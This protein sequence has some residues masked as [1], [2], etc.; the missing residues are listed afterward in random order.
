MSAQLQSLKDALVNNV[1]LEE[2]VEVNQRHLI[3]KILARYSAEFTV[4]RELLQNSN[5]AGATEVQIHFQTNA[6]TR[7]PSLLGKGPQVTTVIYKNNGRPFSDEDFGR[8]RKIAE[9]NPDEQKI[10]FFGVGF[11]SLFSICEEPFVTSGNQSMAFLWKGDMLYTKK[12]PI[13]ESEVSQWTCFFLGLREPIDIPS[14]QEFGKFLATSL[15][16]TANLKKVEVFVDEDRTLF[17]DKKIADP[18]PL[19]FA[20]GVYTLTSPNRMF[21]LESVVIRH[22]Q[23]DVEVLPKFDK[24]KLRRGD[25]ASHTIFMRTAGGRLRVQLDANL[26]KEMERTTKKRPPQTTEMQIMFS[27]FDEYESSTKSG[28]GE[29][30]FEDLV[31]SLGKQGRVFIGNQEILSVSGLLSRILYEDDMASIARLYQEMSLDA[32]SVTWLQNRAAHTMASFTYKPSTPSPLVGRILGMYFFQ[33]GKNPLSILS[34]KGV[35][36]ATSVRIMNEKMKGF[37]KEV[38]VIPEVIASKCTDMVEALKHK[39]LR[40]LGLDDVFRELESRS[41]NVEEMVAVMRWWID[42][43]KTQAVSQTELDRFLRSAVVSVGDK[44]VVLN[45]IRS[46]ANSKLVPPDLPL[47]ETVLP[48]EV[49]KNFKKE[50]LEGFFGSWTELSLYEWAVH[51]TNLADF[52]SDTTLVGKILGNISRHYGNITNE[53]RTHLISLLQ[54]KPCIPTKLGLKPPKDAYFKTVTLFPDLPIVDLKSPKSVSDTFLRALGVREHVELQ[55]VFDR[56][57]TLNWD[58]VQLVKYLS[59]V[60]GKLQ[61]VEI[62]RL[63]IS[64]L[65]L[66]EGAEEGGKRYRA[67]E[68]FAP[69]DVLRGFGVPIFS[70]KGKWKQGTDEARFMTMLGMQTYLPVETLVTLASTSPPATRPK[71]LAYFVDHH[72]TFYSHTYNPTTI[73]IPFLPTTKGVLAK[74]SEVFADPQSGVMG[75][76]VLHEELRP[77]AEKFGVGQHPGVG[78]LMDWLRKN[79]VQIERAGEVFGYLATRQG[80]FTRDNWRELSILRFIPVQ[81]HHPPG[82][83]YLEPTVVYFA[84]NRPGVTEAVAEDQF[85]RVDFG[86]QANHFLR[87]AGVKDEPSPAELAAQLVGNPGRFLSAVGVDG[88]LV[89]LRQVAAHWATLKGDARLVERMKKSSWVLGQRGVVV[90]EEKE[91][92]EGE[93]GGE[94]KKEEGGVEYQLAKPSEVYLADDIVLAQTF[95]PLSAP[96][97]DLLEKLYAELG[98]KWLSHWV[99]E[100][101]VPRGHPHVSRSSSQLEKLIHERAPLLLYDGHQMR[102]PRDLVPDAEKMLRHVTCL[103]VPDIE[104]VRKFEGMVKKG[105]GTAAVTGGGARG[106]VTVYV[107][108]DYDHFDVARM[109]GTALLR[110]CKLND[111]LILSTL[112][113]SSI[114]NLRRKGFP[115]DRILGLSS[116]K[117]KK[118]TPVATPPP[119]AAQAPAGSTETLVGDSGRDP[120]QQQQQQKDVPGVQQLK[121]M[122][123]DADEGFLRREVEKAYREGNGRVEDVIDRMLGG[124]YP[125]EQSMV[126]QPN[127]RTPGD[128]QSTSQSQ[129]SGEHNQPGLDLNTLTRFTRDFTRSLG[130]DGFFGSGPATPTPEREPLIQQQQ[131]TTTVRTGTTMPTEEVKITPGHT[132]QLKAHLEQS[133]STL[134]GTTESNIRATIPNDPDP[135]QLPPSALM[136]Q[137]AERCAIISDSDLVLSFSVR[138][139]PVYIDRALDV[140]ETK[141]LLGERKRES[142]ERFVGVLLLL[143]QKVFGIKG[144]GAVHVYYDKGGE[145]VAFNRSKTVFFNVRWFLGLHDEEG[146][147]GGGA[148]PGAWGGGGGGQSVGEVKADVF[149]YWFLT[150]CHELGH[151]FV[152]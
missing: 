21:T 64:P 8:L 109:L 15:G 113:S 53:Q 33:L 1:A 25:K 91:E 126:K 50:E 61:D 84:R 101:T 123:P 69:G 133:I 58:Q 148:M 127:T 70:W 97:D 14:V 90:T 111:I 117:F 36:P 85:T 86:T 19:D 77:N 4:F 129:E 150:F 60:Q 40:P 107:V 95:Q 55:V 116:N 31:P 132:S 88:Y 144:N 49:A 139:V 102:S 10:G 68:L 45:S 118:V 143:S 122:F 54:R 99:Q 137:T 57:G 89:S 134:R 51:V 149:Y 7:R 42:Y 30:L 112:L 17:F 12:G 6:A 2:K 32:E 38:P 24:A 87:A 23:L 5:D 37:I 135:S 56:L 119:V 44:T 131:R 3:D 108:G 78:T 115:V 104:I 110:R 46:H 98:S 130:L 124:E 41:F 34:S 121:S 142:V 72:K 114:V 81:A 28:G 43:R 63:K 120:G 66:R 16:F 71:L 93:A 59:S 140:G 65:F 80:D 94:T 103:E 9:G 100:T 125:K 151:N 128:W 136:R 27:N 146:G 62:S 20:K 48:L 26:T 18:R 152:G 39:G 22:I 96:V 29:G 52:S 138:G 76:H 92:E 11:Y 67:G 147:K 35:M 82:T 105:R 145:T 79:N 47:P 13:P 141:A 106:P 74:P 75:F 83:T 73:T